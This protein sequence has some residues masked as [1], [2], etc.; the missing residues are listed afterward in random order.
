MN[1]PGRQPRVPL[2]RREGTRG[3][4]EL[5]YS[6]NLGTS[7]I[8]LTFWPSSSFTHALCTFFVSFRGFFQPRDEPSAQTLTC[9]TSRPCEF[10][11]GYSRVVRRGPYIFASG[12]T[13]IEPETG[14][15]SSALTQL[16]SKH[17]SFSKRLSSTS[18][19]AA[20]NDI[21]RVRVFVTQ[22]EGTEAVWRAQRMIR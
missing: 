2:R 10:Q 11:F 6:A 18:G 13:S 7:T 5:T 9:N 21:A 16:I 20:K 14:V 22:Q 15:T 17:P 3:R 12:R 8:E 19:K 1:Q 4:L